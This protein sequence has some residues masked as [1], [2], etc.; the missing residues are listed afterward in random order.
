MARS[1]LSPAKSP[2]IGTIRLRDSYDLSVAKFDSDPRKLRLR[3]SGAVCDNISAY[4]GIHGGIAVTGP[5][6]PR[7]FGPPAESARYVFS[8]FA[9]SLR[10]SARPWTCVS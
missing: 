8:I 4:E 2:T 6:S 9:R 5:K 10:S 7:R 3:P 1:A